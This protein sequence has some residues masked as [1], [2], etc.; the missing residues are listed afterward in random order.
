MSSTLRAIQQ[1]SC[2]IFVANRF[3]QTVKVQRTVTVTCF[4]ALHLDETNSCK[5]T[6]IKVRCTNALMFYF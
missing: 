3:K 1:Q 2:L 5:A 6:N 4:G